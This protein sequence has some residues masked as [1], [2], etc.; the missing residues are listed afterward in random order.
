MEKRKEGE[1]HLLYHQ[2][3]VRI[4]RLRVATELH[5]VK[6]GECRF[7]AWCSSVRGFDRVFSRS[8]IEL[9]FGQWVVDLKIL[10]LYGEIVDP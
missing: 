6:E 8:L 4:E 7:S 9:K 1:S 2:F 5:F 3:R 10:I